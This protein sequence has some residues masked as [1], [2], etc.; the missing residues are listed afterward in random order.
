M[1]NRY[2]LPYDVGDISRLPRCTIELGVPVLEDVL[3]LG[4]FS[5]LPKTGLYVTTNEDNVTRVTRVDCAPL[6][7]AQLVTIPNAAAGGGMIHE[8]RPVFKQPVSYLQ[9]EPVFDQPENP[10][11]QV[12]GEEMEIADTAALATLTQAIGSAKLGLDIVVRGEHGF[13]QAIYSCHYLTV[14]NLRI[15]D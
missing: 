1:L 13:L 9:Y 2:A 10:S 14:W 5:G 8:R 11:W 3:Q 7:V 12:T 4:D 15:T 6:Q